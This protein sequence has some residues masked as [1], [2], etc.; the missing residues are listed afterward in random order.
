VLK[1]CFEYEIGL[2]PNFTLDL[3]AKNDI[4]KYVVTADDKLI[5]GQ[6]ARIQKQFGIPQEVVAADSDVTGTFERRKELITQPLLLLIF[7][8]TKRLLTCS[9]VKVGD[10]DCKYKGLFEDDH[11]LMD[12]MKVNHDDVQV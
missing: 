3:E 1:N 4:V 7:S 5:D 2:V 6:V 12:V 8:R 10:S 9:S 11:Q